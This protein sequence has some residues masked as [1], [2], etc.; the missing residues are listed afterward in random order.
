MSG[1]IAL[2]S[3]NQ[4]VSVA[5][6]KRGINSLKH[7]GS[8]QQFWVSPHDQIGLG[9]TQLGLNKQTG[10][11]SPITHCQKNLHLIFDGEFYDSERLQNDL[12]RWGYQLPNNS[13][14]EVVLY[15]YHEL[16]TQCLHSLRGEFAFIIW[17][18]QNQLLFAVRDRFGI[19]PLYYVY[20]DDILYLASEVK[21]LF[22]MGIQAS[23]D[24]ESFLQA[25][26]GVLTG[27]RTLFDKVYQVPPGHFLLASNRSIQLHSYWDFNYPCWSQ[28]STPNNLATYLEQLRY[29]LDEAI[30]LRLNMNTSVGYYLSGGIDSS[31]ILAIAATHQS[32]PLHA[33]T[34]AFD[35][36][37]HNE[38]PLAR[39]MADHVG[40]HLHVVPV[41]QFDLAD[42]LA[43]AIWHSEM[44]IAN[45]N[46]SAKYLLSRAV[47]NAGY[48]VVLAG[49]GSDEIF[50][51][52]EF[53]Y[54]DMLRHNVQ[55]QDTKVIGPLREQ[56]LQKYDS[57]FRN[58]NGLVLNSVQRTLGFVPAWLDAVYNGYLRSQSLY[59]PTFL[60]QVKQRN[61]YRIFLNQI[62]I[63][64]QLVD[65]EPVHQSLYLW[66]KTILP[67]YLLRRLS[68]SVE[69]AHSIKGRLPFLDHK[70]VELV[71]EIP[72]AFKLYGTIEKYVLQQVVQPLLIPNI[73]PRAFRA[74]PSIH[75]PNEALHQLIQDTLR[76]SSMA[77]VPFYNQAA[78]IQLLDKLPLMDNNQRRGIDPL[79]MKIFS[80]CVLQDRFKLSY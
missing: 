73:S 9:I 80:T 15:L 61:V 5:T 48:Q 31:A 74:P 72:V 53:F 30:T 51:G 14:N 8:E 39:Q 26:G 71:N 77:Q 33:F 7:R 52:Y 10:H 65:R 69:M 70:W 64:G 46:V 4:P 67:N 16:G 55:G 75:K 35:D 12:T 60:A 54:Q 29:A 32:Q 76:S 49:D 57:W 56:E 63:L 20:H 34:I 22:A 40:A 68:D 42:H 23:W 36:E 2:F 37:S 43:N 66:C 18:E 11:Q 19:K 3:N 27:N 1:I 45:A 62:D 50:G 25:D 44:L 79:L 24:D 59:S 41:G 38:E 21:A 13:S 6:M 58:E 78:I 28:S 47:R 17:D